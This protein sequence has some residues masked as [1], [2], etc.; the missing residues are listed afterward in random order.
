MQK[1]YFQLIL[2]LILASC[3]QGKNKALETIDLISQNTTE[4]SDLSDIASNI[5]YVPLQTKD[6]CLIGRMTTMKAIGDNFYIPDFSK[7]LCFDKTGKYLYQLSKNGRGPGEYEFLMD[8]D[9]NQQNS[10]LA[11]KSYKSILLYKQ[12]FKGFVFLNKVSLQVT[13]RKIKFLGNQ[14]H[15]IL[16]YSNAEGKEDYSLE[17]INLNGETLF[18][19]SNNLRFQLKG[20]VSTSLGD[21][22]NYYLNDCVYLKELMSDTMFRIC[23]EL[24]LEPFLIFETGQKRVTPEVRSDGKYYVSHKSEYFHVEEILG[25]ER[26]IYYTYSFKG[27][28]HIIYDKF[29]RHK[30]LVKD[31][32]F[33]RD[34]LGGGLNFEP[35]YCNNGIFYSWVEPISLKKFLAGDIFKNAIV[36]NPEKKKELEKLSENL[37]DT[38]NPVLIRVELKK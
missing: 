12:T 36:I 37:K 19:R 26:Y 10:L 28:G 33:L 31:K 9:V 38:D 8:F 7:I 23:D 29:S 34:D 22:I 24:K 15:L 1:R 21:N 2:I 30:Y 18:T 13:P 17:I 35:K 25:S 20:T 14:G 4:L 16:Q 32:I 27:Y 5:D 11:V 3:K 6:S